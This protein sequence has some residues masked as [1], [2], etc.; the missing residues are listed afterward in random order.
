MEESSSPRTS[1]SAERLILVVLPLTATAVHLLINIF[2]G[3]GFFRDELYYI[4]CSKHLD[5]GYVDHPPFSIAV[6]ALV[7]WI[8]GESLVAV[9]L[10]PALVSGL[11]VLVTG[12][13]ARALGGRTAALVSSMLAAVA[14]PIFLAMGSFYSM[15]AFDIL[16]WGLSAFFFVRILNDGGKWNWYLL[17]ASLGIGALNKISILWLAAG[18][19]LGVLLTPARRLLRQKEPT[20]AVALVFAGMIPYIIWNFQ[21]DF[22]TLEFIRNATD[23]KYASVTA[24]DFIAGQFLLNNPA[25]APLWMAGLVLLLIS[26][27]DRHLR[28]L[29]LAFLVVLLILL[30][31]GRSKAEYLSPAYVFLFAAGGVALERVRTGGRV[32]WWRPAYLAVVGAIGILMA[33]FTMP[34]LPVETFIA[35]QRSLAPPPQSVEGHELQEL[36]QY[37]ADMFGW[38]ELA[39]T[40]SKVYQTIPDSERATAAVYAQN[41]GEAAALEYYSARYI[42][43]PV[44]SRHNN[45][46][47]WSREMAQR[48]AF[49]TMIIIGG[50]RDDHLNSLTDVRPAAIHRAAYSMPY[51]NDLTIYVGRGWKRPLEEILSSGRLF[52]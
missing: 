33:P 48:R 44:L 11:F 4:A 51:E 38:E 10:I 50:R 28:P 14:S 24:V 43:P 21:H 22:A 47:F 42:L 7:R 9:R 40:V 30:I 6:L 36:P 13:T 31:N 2:G 8:L 20:I 34:L 35:Y 23:R 3:Y 29:G 37:F 19:G 52:I 41:Y 46:W 25:S 12:L 32:Q 17:G 26:R 45:Y 16:F 5:F 15:N 39:R 1:W 27:I 18:I 49:K